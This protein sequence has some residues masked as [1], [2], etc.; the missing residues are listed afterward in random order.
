[1]GMYLVC[2]GL[3]PA[4][5]AKGLLFNFSDQWICSTK[6]A[7]LDQEPPPPHKLL[8]TPYLRDY[9]DLNWAILRGSS[10]DPRPRA[11]HLVERVP[12]WAGSW[13]GNGFQDWE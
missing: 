10:M 11:P 4:D 6:M 3:P 7:P 5:L 9:G 12:S 8:S 1:M 13:R 2:R